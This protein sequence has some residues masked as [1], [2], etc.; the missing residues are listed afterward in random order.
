M[1]ILYVT[2]TSPLA[3]G[4]GGEERARQVTEGLASRGHSVRIL[5]GKTAEE[6]PKRTTFEGCTVRHVACVPSFVFRF[7]LLSFYA[8]RYLFAITSLPVVLW[9][10]WTRD[11]DVVVENMTPYA[12]LTVALASLSRTPIVAVQHEFYDHSCYETY[13]PITATI[14]LLVQNILRTGKYDRVIVPTTHVARR[15][16]EYGID[17]STLAVVPNGVD[18]DKYVRRGVNRDPKALVTVG[19]LSKRKGQDTVLRAFETVQ[20]QVR[21]VHLH[22]VGDGPAREP[23]ESLA[24]ELGIRESVTFHGFVTERRKIEL[25]NRSS[26][27]VFA[28]RQEGFGLVL[29]EAMAANLPVVATALPVYRD[30]FGNEQRGRLLG[31]RDTDEFAAAVSEFLTDVERSKTASTVNRRTAEEFSWDSTVVR[32]EQLLAE[33]V[34]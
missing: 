5:C 1:D 32:T 15:L 14:Q 22:V 7:S 10:L 34:S 25:L 8:T 20:E 12:S 23:L 31:T 30:F 19:R 3:D 26:V 29:L 33:V 27:F 2:K 24:D 28:S 9:V 13:D 18:V 4:G 16:A 11:V 6:L 21:D 17:D